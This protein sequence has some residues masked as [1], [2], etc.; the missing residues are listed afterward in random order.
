MNDLPLNIT[1]AQVTFFAD[2]TRIITRGTST[3]EAECSMKVALK[4]A[5]D[6]F[7]VNKLLLTNS[8]NKLIVFKNIHSRIVNKTCLWNYHNDHTL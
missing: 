2:N 5:C 7:T 3:K 8:K 1:D 6:W 4:D